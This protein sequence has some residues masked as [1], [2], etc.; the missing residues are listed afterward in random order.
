MI[1]ER[2][3]FAS[4]KQLSYL[5][6]PPGGI[7]IARVGGDDRPHHHHLPLSCEPACTLVERERKSLHA[8]IEKL[9]LE[10]SIPGR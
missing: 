1:G 2:D 7:L 4:E 8:G 6:C 5:P 3:T 9:D 10:Q